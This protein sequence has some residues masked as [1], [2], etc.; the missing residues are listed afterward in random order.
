VD[1][2]VNVSSD[3]GV[4]RN[5]LVRAFDVAR[6]CAVMYYPEANVLVSRAVDPVSKT[7]A[8]KAVVATLEPVLD[9]APRTEVVRL[10]VSGSQQQGRVG[11]KAC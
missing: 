3:V 5:V 6:G 10:T 11:M 9:E 8:F 4:M 1:Q 7:P 2:R